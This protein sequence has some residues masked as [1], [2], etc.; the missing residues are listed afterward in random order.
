M[1]KFLAQA[2]ADLEATDKSWMTPLHLAVRN[3]TPQIVELLADAGANLEA[4]DVEYM[5]PI[6]RAQQLQKGESQSVLERAARARTKT[7]PKGN[8]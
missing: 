2:G 7:K 5:T 4:R 8:Q 3:S 6:Q 1:V